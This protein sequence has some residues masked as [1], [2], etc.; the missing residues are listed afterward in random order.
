MVSHGG[1]LCPLEVKKDN[2]YRVSRGFMDFGPV[3]ARIAW[4]VT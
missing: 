1:L 2:N 3:V 4:K